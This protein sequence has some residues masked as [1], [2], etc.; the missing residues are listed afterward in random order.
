MQLTATF[1]PMETP[2]APP[3]KGQRRSQFR[4]TPGVVYHKL[5]KEIEHL[6]GRQVIIEAG[7]DVFDIRNDGWPRSNARPSHSGV[8]IS[9]QSQAAGPLSFECNTYT[10]I[11]DN[12]HAIAKTLEALRAVERHGAVKGGQQYREWKQLPEQPKPVADPLE[13]AAQVFADACGVSAG[14]VVLTAPGFRY[15]EEAYR[16]G[17]KRW[18][19]DTPGGDAAKMAALNDARDIL[20]RHR[21]YRA[22]TTPA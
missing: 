20:R 5:A 8:R 7:Y 16:A 19:P 21:E 22:H 10:A 17:A 11:D 1:R 13:K 9:F 15:L 12:L 18:H 2:L 4:T 3:K 14:V 6:G